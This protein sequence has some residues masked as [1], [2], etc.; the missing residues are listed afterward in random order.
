MLSNPESF[1]EA[2]ETNEPPGQCK[3]AH[4]L[5]LLQSRGYTPTRRLRPS[6]CCRTGPIRVGTLQYKSFVHQSAV[7]PV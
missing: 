3:D 7:A 2:L 4:F 5:D 1:G 6:K